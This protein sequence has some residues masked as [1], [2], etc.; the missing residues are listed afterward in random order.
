MIE[1]VRS[2]EEDWQACNTLQEE[3]WQHQEHAIE[4]VLTARRFHPMASH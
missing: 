2:G 3:V 1:I 4:N